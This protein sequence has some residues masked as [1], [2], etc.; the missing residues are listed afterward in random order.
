MKLFLLYSI[1]INFGEER[2]INNSSKTIN[3]I[4]RHIALVLTKEPFSMIFQNL[5][6]FIYWNILLKVKYITIY[7]PFNVLNEKDLLS[8]FLRVF[9]NF[10]IAFNIRGKTYDSKKEK[11][12][13]SIHEN[14]IYDI[15]ISVINFREGNHEIYKNIDQNR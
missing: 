4:P 1:L 13:T 8:S 15:V 10:R 3:S 11:Y 7:D 12:I 5:L 14:V 9:V 6:K 2:F